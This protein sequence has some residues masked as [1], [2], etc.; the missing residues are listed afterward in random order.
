[1]TIGCLVEPQFSFRENKTPIPGC[2]KNRGFTYHRLL[3]QRMTQ[4]NKK[5]GN[6]KAIQRLIEFPPSLCRGSIELSLPYHGPKNH[7]SIPQISLQALSS[8]P[9]IRHN[10]STICPKPWESLRA[11][12]NRENPIRIKTA[13][14]LSLIRMGRTSKDFRAT[15]KGVVDSPEGLFCI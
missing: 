2:S 10:R 12:R 14:W 15:P 6:K 7:A 3:H 13:F 1:M 11:W 4:A 9:K 5:E 8:S